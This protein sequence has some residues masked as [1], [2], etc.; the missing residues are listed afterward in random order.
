MKKKLSVIFMTITACFT[1]SV[2]LPACG[3]AAGNPNGNGSSGNGEHVH[4][5]THTVAAAPTCGMDGNNEY[6][7]CAACDNYFA[8]NQATKGITQEEILIFSTENHQYNTSNICTACNQKKPSEG[9]EFYLYHDETCWVTGIGTCQDKKIIIPKRYQGVLVTRIGDGAF[10]GCSNLSSITIPNS[11]TT[12]GSSA[13]AYCNDLASITIPDSVTSIGSSAFA[14]CN[15]LASITIPD[16]VTS[17]GS[18]AFSGCDEVIQ[19]VNRVRY[20]DKWA[21]GCDASATQVTLRKGTVGIAGD[22]FNN[23]TELLSITIPNSVKGKIPAFAS[24]ENL[25]RV[26]YMGTIDEWASKI[27]LIASW[28]N[29]TILSNAKLYINNAEV[30]EVNL[31]TATKINDSAFMGFNSLTSVIIGDSVT[32]IGDDAFYNCSNLA[33]VTI[34]NSVESIGNYAFRNCSD[35]AS[36]TIPK[37]VNSIGFEAFYNCSSL[38][39]ITIPNSVTTIGDSAFYNC[40][41]LANIIYNGTMVQWKAI[42]KGYDWNYDTGNYTVTCADGVLD[43]NGEQI[44]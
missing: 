7:Y 32:S 23:C 33:S 9:L 11:V 17:I 3:N 6:W 40:S 21:I 24:C 44:S 22:A 13:F 10:A 31:T 41:S 42:T 34:G 29:A 2:V 25:T 12:I 35:L 38:T 18:S 26:N 27:S 28:N 15:D 19:I 30:T 20:V 4:V 16:S 1:F 37:G 36:I 43:K 39:S 8:D 5:L 14:Y